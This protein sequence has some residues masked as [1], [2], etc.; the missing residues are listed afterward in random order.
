M[1]DQ[2]QYWTHEEKPYIFV[3]AKE[4]ADA[5]ESY[6]VGR[7]LANELATQFDKSK[8]HPAAL[9]TNKYGIG[10]L[11]LFKACL[12]RDYLLMKRNSSHYIF[13]LLQVGLVSTMSKFRFSPDANLTQ[14]SL[15]TQHLFL[16]LR[17]L[18]WPSSP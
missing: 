9:T 11:E 1:K 5:F 17:L 15:L 6:H 4:F 10:K 18:W 12:S 7:S 2:E 16:R 3:T 14:I 8:S 13:K